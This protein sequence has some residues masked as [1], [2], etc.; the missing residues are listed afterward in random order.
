MTL[1]ASAPTAASTTRR[2][3][4]SLTSDELYVLGMALTLRVRH[5]KSLLAIAERYSSDTSRELAALAEAV[6][7]QARV[8][9]LTSRWAPALSADDVDEIAGLI[10]A[11]ADELIEIGWNSTDADDD[12]AAARG[13]HMRSIAHDFRSVGASLL[14]GVEA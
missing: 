6:T 9:G 2:Y 13:H 1:T 4:L 10:D 7:L 8:T 14:A 11:H 3:A 12:D 5:T